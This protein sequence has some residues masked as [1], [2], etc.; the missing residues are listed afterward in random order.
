MTVGVA[1]SLPLPM[2]ENETGF[3]CEGGGEKDKYAAGVEFPL[4]AVERKGK[5]V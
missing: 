1:A 5:D 2:D 4:L 3:A